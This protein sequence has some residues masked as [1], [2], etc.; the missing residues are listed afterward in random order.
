MQKKIQNKKQKRVFYNPN[1][2]GT[3]TPLGQVWIYKAIIMWIIS[4]LFVGLP[5]AL[6]TYTSWVGDICDRFYLERNGCFH[7]FRKEF[8]WIAL[9]ILLFCVG[10]AFSIIICEIVG[11]APIAA[12]MYLLE[13]ERHIGYSITSQYAKAAFDFIFQNKSL[14]QPISINIPVA[15]KDKSTAN[16]EQNSKVEV[17]DKDQNIDHDQN[18][19]YNYNYQV[20]IGKGILLNTNE[21]LFRLIYINYC[22][23]KFEYFNFCE[24]SK[25]IKYLT[26]ELNNEWSNVSLKSLGINCRKSDEFS[27]LWSLLNRLFRYFPPETNRNFRDAMADN[28]SYQCQYKSYHIVK[29]VYVYLM[30]YV[31]LP[32]FIL[33]RLFSIFFPLIAVV[34]FNFDIES[35]QLLQWILTG[36]YAIFMG[37]WVIAAIRCFYFYHWTIRLFPGLNSWYHSSTTKQQGLNLMQKYYNRR[38]NDKFIYDQGRKIVIEILGKDIGRLVVS[39]WPKFEFMEWLK[40]LQQEISKLA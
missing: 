35:I 31:F 38:L 19:N 14:Y 7:L 9:W 10:A 5:T 37:A 4:C 36:L 24:D 40:E 3:I 6:Y 25:L 16:D 29:F 17:E 22:W 26:K 23:I 33:S 11:F 18:H 28:G 20:T 15:K 1:E 13:H 32:V 34:Y 12:Y 39:F 21:Q 30:L 2:P 27:D 8:M